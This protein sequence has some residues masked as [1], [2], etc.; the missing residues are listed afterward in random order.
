MLLKNQWVS[1]RIKEEIKKIPW[2]FHCG[3]AEPDFISVRMWVW[4]LAS[5]SGL[6]IWH[7]HELW[8]SHSSDST[9]SPGNFHMLQAQPQKVKKINSHRY[10][11]VYTTYI[12]VLLYICYYLTSRVVKGV[13]IVAQQK[14]IRLGT[15]KLWV[16][17]LA[18]LSGLRSRHCREL[19]CRSQTQL[20]SCVAVAVM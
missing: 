18:S 9:S 6:R 20:G 8:C 15:M 3:L 5:L 7:C 19:W 10:I 14:Q 16:R 13:P 11:H 1:D 4:S 12:H 17:S 2:V